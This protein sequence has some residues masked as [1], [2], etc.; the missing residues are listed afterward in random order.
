MQH[1]H[2]IFLVTVA[3]LVAGA[4]SAQSIPRPEDFYRV[5]VLVFERLGELRNELYHLNEAPP[6]V[7][8]AVELL[9]PDPFEE[10]E[11]QSRYFTAVDPESRQFNDHWVTLEESPE[12]RPLVHLAW[13]QPQYP[14]EAPQ[15]LRLHG[16]DTLVAASRNPGEY[17]FTDR[18]V[19][20]A[21]ESV[22]ELDGTAAFSRGRFMHLGLDLV[23]RRRSAS[24]DW[25]P[26]LA[27]PRL[28]AESPSRQFLEYRLS[29][30]LR[31]RSDEVYYFDNKH[32][33][34]IAIVTHP[35]SDR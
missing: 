11:A 17:V 31:I 25:R 30:R 18:A 6:E 34:A 12:Y 16:G 14:F 15:T 23:L 24:G 21:R 8:G 33:G 26:G 2:R 7:T 9:D 32:F 29:E 28:D 3:C 4:V 5:E 1:N 19:A 35:Y 27:L 13:E 20:S 10:A 22:L